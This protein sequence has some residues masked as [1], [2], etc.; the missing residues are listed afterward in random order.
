MM[1]YDIIMGRGIYLF[2][3]FLDFLSTAITFAFG[4]R[5]MKT[6]MAEIIFII[7][8]SFYTARF[9]YGFA[10]FAI[11][12]QVLVVFTVTSRNALKATVRVYTA[13]IVYCNESTDGV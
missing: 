11:L 7:Y 8:Y 12:T 4:A 6:G 5:F 10:F 2:M 9:T 1:S 13:H 3:C